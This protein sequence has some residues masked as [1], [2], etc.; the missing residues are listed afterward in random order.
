MIK[1]YLI[2]SCFSTDKKSVIENLLNVQ[3]NHTGYVHSFVPFTT[4][5][6]CPIDVKHFPFDEQNCILLVSFCFLD[7]GISFRRL[8]LVR[9]LAFQWWR[10]SPTD[11][12][13][14]HK[15]ECRRRFLRQSRMDVEKFLPA[16][17]KYVEQKQ[18]GVYAFEY[19]KAVFL[20]YFQSG[21][22]KRFDFYRFRGRL[23]SAS[24]LGWWSLIQIQ[25]GYDDFIVHVGSATV[26]GQWASEVRIRSCARKER[27]V[28][29]HTIDR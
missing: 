21:Y 4:E 22:T 29:Q 14:R 10:C 23:S 27:I 8:R 13:R 24:S 26:G 2:L 9:H 3:V 19:R 25:V 11:Q 16:V 20:L 1:K 17:R 6:I 5:T 28:Q 12:R 7:A 18:Y 15:L